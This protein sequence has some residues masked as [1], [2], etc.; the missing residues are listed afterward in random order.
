MSLLESCK[1][2]FKNF[3]P[4]NEDKTVLSNTLEWIQETAPSDAIFSSELKKT[5]DLF[6]GTIEIVAKAGTFIA[7]AT[8][9]TPVD[10]MFK[11]KHNIGNQM[12]TWKAHRFEDVHTG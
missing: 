8:A 11:L 9:K 4:S 5:K 10:L 2:K 1:L 3:N 7:H 6:I 12:K